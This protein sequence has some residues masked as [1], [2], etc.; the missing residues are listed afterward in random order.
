MS[1]AEIAAGR[2]KRKAMVF[3]LSI[4]IVEGLAGV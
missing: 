1:R 4:E 2:A 3:M